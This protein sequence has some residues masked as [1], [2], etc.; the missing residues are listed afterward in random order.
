MAL[1]DY[2]ANGFWIENGVLKGY[3]GPGGDIAIP[4]GVTRIDYWAFE[5]CSQIT[6]VTVPGSVESINYAAFA[7]CKN[8]KSV[9][10][11]DGVVALDEAL[12]LQCVNLASVTVPA[13][14]TSVSEWTFESYTKLNLIVDKGSYIHEKCKEYGWFYTFSGEDYKDSFTI[15]NG[16][17]TA[18]TGNE[19]VVTIPKGVTAIGKNVFSW[20]D[21]VGDRIGIEKVILPEGVKSLGEMAFSGCKNLKEI[22][23]PSTLKTVN[24]GAFAQCGFTEV[25]VPKTLK[26]TMNDGGMFQSCENLEKVTLQQGLTSM[27]YAMFWECENLKEVYIPS[28]VKTVGA[29]SFENYENLEKAVLAEGVKTIDWYAFANCTSLTEVV[30]PNTVKTINAGAFEGCYSLTEL[31]IPVSVTKIEKDAFKNCS[32]ELVISCV[33]GSAAHKFCKKYG[34]QTK[35]I[36]NHK[37]N[38][39]KTVIAATCTENGEK[40]R[41]CKVCGEVDIQTIPAKGHKEVTLKAVEV[42]CKQDGLSEGKKCSACGEILVEQVVTPALPHDVVVDAYIAPSE[43]ACGRTEGS[44]CTLCK[45]VL[46]AQE[47]IPG[48]MPFIGLTSKSTK[49]ITIN[50]GEYWLLKPEYADGKG[51]EINKWS[52]NAKKIATVDQDGVVCAR[53]EGSVTITASAG[54]NKTMT[55]KIKVVDPKKPSKVSL[56]LKGTQKLNLGETLQLNATLTPDTAEAKFTWKSS[57]KK[58]AKVENGLVTPVAEGT[59]TITVTAT[60]GKVKKTASVKVKVEDPLKLTKVSLD[61]SGTQKLAVGESLTLTPTLNPEGTEATIKWK[62]SNKKVASVVDGVVTARKKGKAVITVTAVRGKVTKT[63]KVTIQVK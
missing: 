42:S 15:K 21:N 2:D 19:A 39:A 48:L 3:N 27:G 6:G 40:T 30:I 36:C 9:I 51:W 35:V 25:T 61:K 53:K 11:C 58:I 14:V 12:F 1:A 23:F 29:S 8:L 54:K 16:I 26:L 60:R 18:Y 17:L 50:I 62:S 37:W 10:L 22:N 41:S 20:I 28:S 59:A 5:D 24:Y 33:A 52:T 45:T 46:V 4:D 63:A 57:N 31:T 13:S 55:V 56:D 47:V 32:D 49:G 44:H 38:K 43:T 34:I 7:G